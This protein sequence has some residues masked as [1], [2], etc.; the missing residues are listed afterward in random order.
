MN[1]PIRK[2]IILLLLSLPFTVMALSTDKQQP[3]NIEADWVD[4]NKQKGTSIYKGR[5]I[6]TQGS[7]RI[8]SDV[9]TVYRNK[10]GIEKIIATGNP[11]KF[12]QR[13][14]NETED[15]RGEGKR[16]EYFSSIDKLH[17]Y[18][19]AVLWQYKDVFTGD[20]INYDTRQ[21]VVRATGK[22]GDS[23]ERVRVTIQPTN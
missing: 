1:Q 13:P 3:V 23:K 2:A 17:L 15:I 5:V 11:A 10:N 18:E 20:H 16:L 6:I 22:P 9:A 14:D 4:V 7:I 8:D 19:K 21:H 12:R